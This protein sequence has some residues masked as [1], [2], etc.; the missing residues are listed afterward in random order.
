VAVGREARALQDVPDLAPHQRY[1]EH[2][3][4]VG[5][6]GVQA[7]EAPL[8]D[9]LAG[10]VELLDADVV[11]IRRAVDDRTRVGLGEVEQVRLVG[12]PPYFGR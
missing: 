8:A 12:E 10:V 3:H 5:G 7:E 2:A 1:L 4:A 9:D 6:E 11:H